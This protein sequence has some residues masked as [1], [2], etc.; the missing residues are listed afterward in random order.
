MS[1]DAVSPPKLTLNNGVRMPALGL[2]VFQVPDEQARTAVAT[3]LS[4]GYRSV[5]TAAA[6]FNEVG[7]GQGIADADLA[8]DEV[9][10]TTKLWNDD[11]GFESTLRAAEQSLRRLRLDY[12]DLY[13]IHWPCPARG[14][15]V[16]S[17]R[18]L[19]RLLSDGFARAIGVSN[20]EP[21]QLNRLAAEG[22][23]PPAV[24]QIE[25]HPSHQR[26]A[27]RRYHEQH[28]ILTEAWSPLGQGAAL[29]QPT[30]ANLASTHDRTPAQVVLRWH[31]QLGN[32]V[33]PKSVTPSRIAENL[34]V[35][36]FELSPEEMATM[37]TLNS[38]TD[39]GIAP[40]GTE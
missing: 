30:V 17:W 10:V 29:M 37:A 8:R 16:E 40:P 39:L 31:L 11:Q 12:V 15:Y 23:V 20:F 7:V 2:G 35:F 34:D 33:I 25:L 14:L 3:A 27:L 13:L 36:G 38:D 6:Y 4:S 24:N 28:G 5:D 1:P 18:A 9:F 32:A 19:E 26:P 22:S 21:E